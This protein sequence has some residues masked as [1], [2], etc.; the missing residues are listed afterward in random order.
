[1]R[2]FWSESSNKGEQGKDPPP[3]TDDT[4]EKDNA[5][6]MPNGALMIFRGSTAYDSK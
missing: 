6:P 4:E 2:K 1:M 3:A 5:F